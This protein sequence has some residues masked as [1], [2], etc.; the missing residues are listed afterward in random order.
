MVVEN[1]CVC[2]GQVDTETASPGT[3][4]KYKDIGPWTASQLTPHLN[5][6]MG[7]VPRLPIHDHVASIL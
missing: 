1:H 7:H 2:S 6:V 5:W 3:E 4:N